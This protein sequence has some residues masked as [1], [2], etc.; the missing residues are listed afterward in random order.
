MG[1]PSC[2]EGIYAPVNMIAEYVNCCL[3]CSDLNDLTVPAMDI[4]N[5]YIQVQP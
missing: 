3:Y 2:P 4:C 5:A 1:F